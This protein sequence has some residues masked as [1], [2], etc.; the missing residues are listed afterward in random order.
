MRIVLTMTHLP[1]MRRDI[2]MIKQHLGLGE[3][4]KAAG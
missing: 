2:K 3:Q 1:A 4:E